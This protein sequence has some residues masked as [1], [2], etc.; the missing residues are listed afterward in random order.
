MS[1]LVREQQGG[2]GVVSIHINQAQC[3]LMGAV[4]GNLIFLEGFFRIGKG[5]LLIHRPGL[6]KSGP[7]ALPEHLTDGLVGGR[8][9]G[10]AMAYKDAGWLDALVR[11]MVGTL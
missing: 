7:V 10:Y 11:Q 6:V 9:R 3:A 1:A 2:V 5:Q 8:N 4:K